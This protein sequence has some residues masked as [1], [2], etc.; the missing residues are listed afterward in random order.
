MADPPTGGPEPHPANI[1]E[2]ITNVAGGDHEA[3]TVTANLLSGIR[4]RTRSGDAFTSSDPAGRITTK[5]V[6]N[7]I[8]SLK[9]IIRQQTAAIENT[10][11]E[12]QEIK[13]NHN[14]L[15]E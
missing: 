1:Q 4:K 11:N 8:G 13:H 9:D 2:N 15:Q 5:E 10:Q 12:L 6:W 7:P 14:V 3:R